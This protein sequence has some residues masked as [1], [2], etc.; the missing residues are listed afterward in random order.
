M[1]GRNGARARFHRQRR[2]KIHNR[3]RIRELWKTLKPPEAGSAR[4]SES[5]GHDVIVPI[6]AG[7]EN[8]DQDRLTAGMP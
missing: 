8:K 6:Q 4:Q 7:I 3:T 1:S 5:T 2:A